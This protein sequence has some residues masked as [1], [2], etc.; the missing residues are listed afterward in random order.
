MLAPT[1]RISVIFIIII[2]TML[3]SSGKRINAIMSLAIR[4]GATLSKIL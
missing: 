4:P 2:V 1:N 3:L